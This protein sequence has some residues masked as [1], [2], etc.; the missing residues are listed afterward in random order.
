MS[1]Y[2][3]RPANDFVALRDIAIGEELTVDY[4]TYSQNP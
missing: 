1:E 3:G 2:P 4:S